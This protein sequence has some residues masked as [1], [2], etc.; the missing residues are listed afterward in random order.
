MN[1]LE[2][3]PGWFL[4]FSDKESKALEAGL[5]ALGYE[6]TAKGLKDFVLDTLE[7]ET[8]DPSQ[9]RHERHRTQDASIASQVAGYLREHPEVLGTYANLGK[10][11]ANMLIQKVMAGIE[12][13]RK[14]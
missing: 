6:N 11:A 1:S 14:G 9:E 8:A 4:T 12:K 10:T 13:A 3:I 7:D 2:P 5:D